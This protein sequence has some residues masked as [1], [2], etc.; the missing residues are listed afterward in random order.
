[1]LPNVAISWV[2]FL[3]GCAPE[4]LGEAT[5]KLAMGEGP[6]PVLDARCYDF[7]TIETPKG[8]WLDNYTM[9]VFWRAINNDGLAFG[10]AQRGGKVSGA[11][12][13]IPSGTVWY[14]D[15]PGHDYMDV[16]DLNN[17]GVMAFGA[18]YA[19]G[20]LSAHVLDADGELTTL[21]NPLPEAT[22]YAAQGLNDVGDVVGWVWDPVLEKYR[23]VIWNDGVP[24]L[25]DS[26]IARNV[27]L[28]D[29]ADDGTVVGTAFTDEFVGTGFV[30]RP[31]EDPVELSYDG[32]D[33]WANRING[34]G[35]V[36][37]RSGQEGWGWLNLAGRTIDA[38]MV[39]PRYTAF[40]WVWRDGEFWKVRVPGAMTWVGGIND[41][42]ELV[43]NQSD[44]DGPLTGFA[45]YP[46]SCEAL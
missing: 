13:D 5:A 19:G 32:L 1:M 3:A 35:L 27:T 37:G 23:G 18:S 46:R 45:A 6:E 11:L 28:T 17:D 22:S 42:G 41:A 31:G 44:W 8:E 20:Y 40:G 16:G 24:V 30:V 4:E 21:P 15:L 33:T 12:Y 25:Y 34:H 43:G 10:Q 36:V 38:R 39:P 29:I 2:V 7:E 9:F 14:Y 26:E